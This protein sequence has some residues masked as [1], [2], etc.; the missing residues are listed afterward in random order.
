MKPTVYVETTIPSYLTAWASRD[1]VRAA[2]QQITR[3]WWARREHFELFTSRLVL[4]ECQAGDTQAAAEH[5]A[6]LAGIPVLEQLDEMADLAESL[7]REAPLPAKAA[8][9]ALHIATTKPHSFAHPRNCP[10]RRTAMTDEVLQ[11]VR[12]AREAFA[13]RHNFDVRAMVADLQKQDQAGDW[14]VV[15]HEPRPVDNKSQKSVARGKQ[16]KR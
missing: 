12:K 5:I 4:Q 13:Q 2:H 6:A 14:P 7:L 8:A 11:E 10:A 3:E 16:P 1:L 15:R 9:D